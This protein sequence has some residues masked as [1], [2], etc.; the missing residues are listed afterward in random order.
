MIEEN[1]DFS[2]ETRVKLSCGRSIKAVNGL[3]D[4]GASG[5]H[6]KRKALEGLKY[7]SKK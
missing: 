4:S 7:K 6:I 3:F 1:S 5:T 2:T